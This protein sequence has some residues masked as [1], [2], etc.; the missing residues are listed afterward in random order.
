MAGTGPILIAYDG[1]PG[2]REAIARAGQILGDHGA[3]VLTVF[4][5]IGPPDPSHPIDAILSAIGTPPEEFNREAERLAREMA[6]DGCR[7]AAAAGVDASP[8]AEPLR[9]SV[10]RTILD[11]AEATDACAVVVGSRGRSPAR[12]LLLGSVSAAVARATERPLLVVPPPKDGA[13][14]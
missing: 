3:I 12:E 9:D 2:A 8:R 4:E 14:A 13:S 6:E 11:A 1:S 7:R 5:P 10:V